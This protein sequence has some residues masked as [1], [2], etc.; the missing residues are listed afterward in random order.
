[1]QK[2]AETFLPALDS[3]EGILM[4]MDDKDGTHVWNFKYRSAMYIYTWFIQMS[5]NKLNCM[6]TLLFYEY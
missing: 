1:L 2:A 6:V 5:E 3:K 4:N